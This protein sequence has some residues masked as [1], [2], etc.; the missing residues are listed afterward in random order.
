M[1]TPYV[2]LCYVGREGKGGGG[3]DVTVGLKKG[4]MTRDRLKQSLVRQSLPVWRPIHLLNS[5]DDETINIPGNFN[6][7]CPLSHMFIK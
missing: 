4:L 1:P 7:P 6:C 5:Y 3:G 2:M